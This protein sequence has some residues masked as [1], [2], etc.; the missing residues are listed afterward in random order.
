MSWIEVGMAYRASHRDATTRRAT[1]PRT[2]LRVSARPARRRSA[3]RTHRRGPAARASSELSRRSRARRGARRARARGLHRAL[4]PP[5]RREESASNTPARRARFTDPTMTAASLAKVATGDLLP[6]SLPVGSDV[7][8]LR[9][10]PVFYG[11]GI[12]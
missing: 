7:F 6:G 5:L 2:S 10:Y 12:D 9:L 11:V 3:R 1:H 4:P 8:H